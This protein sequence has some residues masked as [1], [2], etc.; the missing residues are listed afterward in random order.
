[1]SL[2]EGMKSLYQSG[3]FYLKRN[4]DVEFKFEENYHEV[5]LDPDGVE[6]H[7]L[8]ERE[9]AL[10]GLR[11]IIN[12]VSTLEPGKILDIGCGL[13]WFLSAVGESW[14]RKGIEVSKFASDHATE[15]ASVFNG[16]L[17]EYPAEEDEFDVIV[18][19]HV[20]EHLLAPE[21]TIK[22][23]KRIL[24]KGGYFIVA[25]PDFD[26]AAAR[27]YGENFRL[28][29]DQTHI[30]LFSND[31][32]HRF[33]RSNDFSIVNVEYPYFDTEWFNESS[34]LRVLDENDVSPPFYGSVM[35]FFTINEK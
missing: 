23:V 33:L 11:D 26:S 29:H 21:E 4:R 7:L 13:G 2:R 15:F 12:F 30:S 8:D 3:D 25:T 16:T 20:I 9:H 35:T 5:A 1:M 32:L 6:R 19:N 27:R 17:E 10:D 14:N 24:K 22:I 31:S 28:L 18:M 34:L